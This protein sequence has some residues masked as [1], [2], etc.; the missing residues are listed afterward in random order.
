MLRA[1]YSI[2]VNQTKVTKKEPNFLTVADK[3]LEFL[4]SELLNCAR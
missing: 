3:L 4:V 2:N 1:E